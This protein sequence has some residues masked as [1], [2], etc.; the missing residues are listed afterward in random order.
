MEHTFR[1]LCVRRA[2]CGRVEDMVKSKLHNFLIPTLAS[3][4][5]C[6]AD[7]LKV[8]DLAFSRVDGKVL[9][10][11]D[12]SIKLLDPMTSNRLDTAT[13]TGLHA[14]ATSVSGPVLLERTGFES[15]PFALGD[16]LSAILEDAIGEYAKNLVPPPGA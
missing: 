13:L 4:L 7:L 5:Q 14:S 1:S 8:E 15:A 10:A 12:I 9:G 2:E 16:R 6:G 11:F 3:M